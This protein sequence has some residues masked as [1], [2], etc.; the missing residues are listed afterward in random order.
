MGA[1]IVPAKLAVPCTVR[2]VAL[3]RLPLLVRRVEAPRL[4]FLAKKTL[5]LGGLAVLLRDKGRHR[6][7]ARHKFIVLLI[8]VIQVVLLTCPPRRKAG[9]R[10]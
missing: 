10:H 1:P 3:L 9:V 2:L 7:A 4:E 6:L 5:A 8:K